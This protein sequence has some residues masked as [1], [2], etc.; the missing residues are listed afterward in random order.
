MLNWIVHYVYLLKSKIK[1]TIYI[2]C[3]SDLRR[4]FKQ[5]NSGEN[6][7]TKKYKPW[8][9]IYYEA[10]KSKSDAFMREKKLKHHARWLIE[11]KKR[12]ASSL[13]GNGEG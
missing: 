8:T 10:Y 7:S 5:H 9:L 6:I 12:I 3:T 4:R 11:L 13:D 1:E 2:G